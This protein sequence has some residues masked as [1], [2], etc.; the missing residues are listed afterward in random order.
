MA[1]VPVS[2]GSGFH[3][4][5]FHLTVQTNTKTGPSNKPRRPL[6]MHSPTSTFPRFCRSKIRE[7]EKTSWNNPRDIEPKRQ[8]ER[9]S[10]VGNKKQMKKFNRKTL[11]KKKLWGV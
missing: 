4:L 3:V 10:V 9:V 2:V 6:F 7:I 11:G 1:V 5:G 8:A